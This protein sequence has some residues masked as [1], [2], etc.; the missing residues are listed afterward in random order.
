MTSKINAITT[1]SGGIEVTGDSSGEIELQADGSTIATITSSGLSLTGTLPIADGG[2]GQSTASD[3]RAAL[4]LEIG[5]DVQSYDANTAKYNDTTANFT[6]TLQTSGNQVATQNALGVRN[7]IINGD[8]RIDQRN[9]GASVSSNNS[10]AV[11]RLRNVFTSSGSFTAQQSTTAPDNFTNS[12]VWTVGS[13]ASATS[14]Q[15]ANM[16]YRLEGNTLYQ[17]GLGTSAAKT[18][19]LSFWVRS[20][21]TGTYCAAFIN[22]AADRA[23]VAE[24][25]ISSADT[26]EQKSITL[27]GDTSGTWLTTNGIGLRIQFDLGSGSDYN[28]T[29]NTWVGANDFR[30]TNQTDFI[31]N[32]GATFYITGVQLEVGDTATPFEHRPYD[33]ELQRCQRYYEAIVKTAIQDNICNAH[34]WNTTTAYGVL[35]YATKRAAPSITLTATDYIVRFGGTTNNVTSSNISQL[36]VDRCQ[37]GLVTSG[38]TVGYGAWLAF[39]SDAVTNQKLEISAEL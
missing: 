21:V 1:G 31:N 29:A 6:G 16:Q 25:S 27:T 32:A 38:L 5:T 12:V 33:M 19:T 15:V 11:D 23:Y 14:S 13:A 18:M 20:S 39:D 8:M 35:K 24:Y 17:L 26:W 30:T 28:A 34:C 36:T 4:G 37:F 7:L 22:S 9:A 10:Y 2:T 3:A